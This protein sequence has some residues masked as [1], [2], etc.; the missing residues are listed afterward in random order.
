MTPKSRWCENIRVVPKCQLPEKFTGWQRWLPA[1]FW[2][3]ITCLIYK[4][5]EW[6]LGY[7]ILYIQS[8]NIRTIL[9]LPKLKVWNKSLTTLS[10]GPSKTSKAIEIK[11]CLECFL[12]LCSVCHLVNTKLSSPTIKALGKIG[13]EIFV[14][15]TP[16]PSPPPKKKQKL[17]TV[18]M[19]ILV[20]GCFLNYKTCVGPSL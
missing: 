3:A 17:V 13:D 15:G 14:P 11:S 7:A 5:N 1:W 10:I 19:T 20:A 4:D 12:S 18:P 16:P 6:F 9:K 8:F 2:W